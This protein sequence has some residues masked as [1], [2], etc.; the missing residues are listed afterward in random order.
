MI[1]VIADDLTGA[2]ELGGI[3]L[4]HG[5][6]TEVRTIAGTKPPPATDL[7]V[8]AADSRSK[9]QAAAIEE[10]TIITRE[11]RLQKPEWIYKKT[12]SVLRGHVIAE[13]NAHLQALDYQLALL[14]PANPS[15]GRTI[16]NG[17]YYLN[18]Q[19]IHHSSFSTDPEFP[20]RS[21]D[22]QDMLHTKDQPIQVRRTNDQLP[23]RGIVVGEAQ[24]SADLHTWATRIPPKTLLAGAAGFFSAILDTRL[25][26][27]QT[28]GNKQN[29]GSPI[30][31]VSGS[32]FDSNRKLIRQQA[33]KQGPV[34]YLSDGPWEQQV[35][36]QL[37]HHGKAIIAIDEGPH[38]QTALQLRTRMAK[39][40]AGIIKTI[41]PAEL[42][43]EG[44]STA[45][46]ILLQAGWHTF[47]PEEELAQ[48]V[49]RMSIPEAPGLFITVKPGSYRWPP[50]IRY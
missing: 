26:D 43:I 25:P 31:F 36:Q 49:V 4:R 33:D 3:G 19:P 34:T 2:A 21:S 35:I 28:P 5:L 17:H 23:V 20:I 24:T 30:L 15:L 13:L 45:Y 48:G 14:V 16:C 9:P 38:A 11:L 46:A 42:I 37:K 1:A 7:L 50:S 41:P 18:D 32:T 39:A 8:I 12:D 44:G 40:V 29:L 6:K 10:M 27:K 22:L 47:I